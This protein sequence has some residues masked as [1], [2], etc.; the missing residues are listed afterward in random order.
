MSALATTVTVQAARARGA[1]SAA[2][3]ARRLAGDLDAIALR[4][5]DPQPQARYPTVAAL[6]AADA[7][8]S[9]DRA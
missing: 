1:R 5:T 2:Q 9:A 7:V 8:S 6:R 4:A 3:L